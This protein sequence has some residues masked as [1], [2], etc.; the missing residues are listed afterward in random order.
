MRAALENGQRTGP[1]TDLHIGRSLLPADSSISP[2]VKQAPN[3]GH[4]AAPADQSAAHYVCPPCGGGAA[5]DAK[6]YDK[7]GT[8][9]NCG[10]KIY[11]IGKAVA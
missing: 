10:T 4:F 11:K 2:T 8:C 7:P 6:V 9:P 1:H 3:L 5:C